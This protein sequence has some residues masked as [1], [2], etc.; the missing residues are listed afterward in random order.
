MVGSVRGGLAYVTVLVCMLF[1]GV[2][3]TAVSET[4]GLG[5]VLIPSMIKDGYKKN[6]SAALVA[7]ASTMGPIIPP[8]ITFLLYGVVSGTSIG[9]LFLA[10]AIPG[11]LLGLSQMVLI[12]FYSRKMNFPKREMRYSI[13]ETVRIISDTVAALLFPIIIMGGILSGF[14]TPTEASSVAVFYALVCGFVIYKELRIRDLPKIFLESAM[15]SA[16]VLIIIGIGSAFGW[17]MANESVPKLFAGELL[18]I[19]RNPYVLLL[20]INILLLIL[21]TFMEGSA[22]I[23]ILTPVLFPLMTQMGIDPVHFGVIMVLNVI[24]GLCTPPVGL[25]LYIGCQIA[26]TSLEEISRAIFPF[27][28]AALCVLAI[29]TYFPE[30]VMFLP[31]LFLG[32][33]LMGEIKV[34]CIDTL[35][36][37]IHSVA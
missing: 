27:V 20:L 31:N 22:I 9:A 23:I 13:R 29:V 10:G 18:K 2:T 4:S 12:R 6:F 19:S 21:G 8:S 28:L 7:I 14:F 11:V 1:G 3:G 24:I 17:M 25:C 37:L 34:A 5:S 32:F 35:I 30:L 33:N 16:G 26:D 36:L 15:M